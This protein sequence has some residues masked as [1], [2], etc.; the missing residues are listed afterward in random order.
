MSQLEIIDFVYL[1]LYLAKN[2][3]AV[4]QIIIHS[5]RCEVFVVDLTADMLHFIRHVFIDASKE[6]EHWKIFSRPQLSLLLCYI[7]KRVRLEAN[8]RELPSRFT[9]YYCF[10]L[11]TRSINYEVQK[12]KK[13]S[14]FTS[15]DVMPKWLNINFTLEH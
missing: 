13:T 11:S 7:I 14:S 8:E 12:I 4:E 9:C 5:A 2:R 3:P 6:A 15:K 1:P 10:L